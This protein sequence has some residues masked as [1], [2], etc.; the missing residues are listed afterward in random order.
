MKIKLTDVLWTMY[1]VSTMSDQDG[2][3]LYI[4]STNQA[5][6]WWEWNSI[7]VCENYDLIQYQIPQ[8]NIFNIVRLTVR[9]I[10]NE[11]LGVKGL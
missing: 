10:I 2:I 8:T 4:I 1:N 9:R 7:F 11:V 3:S 6:E 5:D